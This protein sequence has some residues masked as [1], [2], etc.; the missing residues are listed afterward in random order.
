MTQLVPGIA[1]QDEPERAQAGD[2]DNI[3][4]KLREIVVSSTLTGIGNGAAP[5]VGV[6]LPSCMITGGVVFIW[7]VCK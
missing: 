5:P 7:R 4:S 6:S 1:T 2:E 3:L